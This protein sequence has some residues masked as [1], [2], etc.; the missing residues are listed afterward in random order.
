MTGHSRAVIG[1]SEPTMITPRFHVA[2]VLTPP[3]LPYVMTPQPIVIATR[4]HHPRWRATF[5]MQAPFLPLRG[6]GP[7]RPLAT[8]LAMVVTQ[9]SHGDA[10]RFTR[11]VAYS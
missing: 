8:V 9:Q 3:M 11:K 7:V 4:D 2:G 5:F 1:A 10:E 6:L